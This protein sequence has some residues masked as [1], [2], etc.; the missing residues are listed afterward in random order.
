M[1]Y[2]VVCLLRLDV[3]LDGIITLFVDAGVGFLVGPLR[4]IPLG[5]LLEYFT[6]LHKVSRAMHQSCFVTVRSIDRMAC[7]VFLSLSRAA[8]LGVGW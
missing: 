4:G 1:G 7:M 5:L 2:Y 3:K 8:L 6:L